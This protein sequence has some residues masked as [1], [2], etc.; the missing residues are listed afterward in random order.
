MSFKAIDPK[1][2][3]LVF[4]DFLN[5]Y[6]RGADEATQRKMEPI[7]ERCVRMKNAAKA[8]GIPSFFPKADHRQDGMDSARLYSD[9]DMQLKAWDD[10][11]KQQFTAF[12]LVAQ[13]DWS[14]DPI[15]ELFTPG[16]DYLIN[17]HRWNSFHQTHLDLSLRSRG[18]DTI[19][20]C[21]GSIEVGIVSTAF[22]ARDRDFN[23]IIV[24]D[25]CTSMTGSAEKAFMEEVFPRFARIRNADQVIEMIRAGA[26]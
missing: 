18:I 24:R 19:I 9:T 26:N 20:L 16:E 23:Q 6:F 5:A 13:N 2:T 7:V 3:G 4:F 14:G 21:G 22:S 15:D 8:V 12:H 25:C 17:K 11:E 10:P 1:R